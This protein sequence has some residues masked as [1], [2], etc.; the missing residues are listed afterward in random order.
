MYKPCV[1]YRSETHSSHCFTP[2]IALRSSLHHSD[3]GKWG[4]VNRAFLTV[5]SRCV[6]DLRKYRVNDRNQPS[7]VSK[8]VPILQLQLAALL[9][10]N[11]HQATTRSPKNERPRSQI[12]VSPIYRTRR[13]APPSGNRDRTPIW[14]P[15]RPFLS[16]AQNATL[17]QFTTIVVKMGHF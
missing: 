1:R 3:D 14:P 13:F 9:K 15:C 17:D 2:H 10:L 11:R 5:G 8:D 12:G 4:S 6:L 16:Q 7:A